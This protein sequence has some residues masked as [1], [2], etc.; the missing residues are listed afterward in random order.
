MPSPILSNF[1]PRR[2]LISGVTNAANAEVTTTEDHG[3]EVG[4]FVRLLVP[5]DYGMAI[6]YIVVEI[7]TVPSTTTFTTDL[8]TTKINSYVTPTTPPSFTD[9]QVVPVSGLEKNNTSITG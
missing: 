5:E 7:L 9:A 6:S 8:D 2:R 4:Q 3:Y 1:Q